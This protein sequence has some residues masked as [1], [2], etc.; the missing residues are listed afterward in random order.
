MQITATVIVLS[1]TDLPSNAMKPTLRV[2]LHIPSLAILVAIA[3]AARWRIADLDFHSALSTYLAD[4]A[5]YYF[6]V[7]ANLFAS[8]RITYDG[9]S[10]TNGFH[11]LWLMLITPL[12]TTANHG[13][14]FVSR[15]QWLSFLL[16]LGSVGMLYVTMLRLGAGWWIAFS[17]TAMFGLHSS[18]IDFQFNGLETSL[19]TLALLGLFN[20]FLTVYQEPTVPVRRYLF[21]G[22][23]AAS[24]FLARTD[25]AIALLVLFI[26]LASVTLPRWQ[27]HKVIASGLLALLL[28]SP[29]LIWNQIN[30]G[31]VVQTSGKLETAFDGEPHFS[32]MG[33]LGKL[34]F[35]PVIIYGQTAELARMYVFPGFQDLL[36]IAILLVWFFSVSVLLVSKRSPPAL[37]AV[38]LFS[39]GVFLVFCYHAGIRN[40]VRSWYFVSA[41]MAIMLAVYGLV[42]FAEKNPNV[43]TRRAAQLS[44]GL[45][46]VSVIGL[47]WPGKLAG[48][49]TGEAPHQAVATWLETHTEPDAVIGSMNS[50]ILSYLTPRKVINLDGVMDLRSLQARWHKQEPTYVHERGINYLVDNEGSLRFFC[51]ENPYHSCETVF[52][53]G[54]PNR[55]NQVVKLIPHH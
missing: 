23:M 32:W 47:H 28:V 10:L 39:V 51:A 37:H 12:Y 16:Q 17:G 34:I 53:F 7:A 46:L 4:D 18:F 26:S 9:D 6:K 8:H 14:D 50:G 41:A 2:S 43:L 36:A 27:L 38:A 11:P 30:F 48:I 1:P 3:L 22:V 40:F 44:M 31:S 49:V 20:A 24:A 42:I 33:L 29:W 35:S 21:F 5:F 54:D 15:V 45:W 25:N 52:T 55:P 19:N 13:E